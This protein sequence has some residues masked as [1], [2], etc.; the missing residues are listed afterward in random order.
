MDVE[1]RGG[2]GAI[3]PRYA[4]TIWRYKMCTGRPRRTGAGERGALTKHLLADGV[5]VLG[6]DGGRLRPSLC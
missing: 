3:Q 5:V 2:G 4:D 6:G 1:S